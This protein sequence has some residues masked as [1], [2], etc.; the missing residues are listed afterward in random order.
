MF[1]YG[2]FAR[3][4]EFLVGCSF[5]WVLYKFQSEADAHRSSSQS[6]R[7]LVPN[8]TPYRDSI[9]TKTPTSLRRTL[10]F[11]DRALTWRW[12][13]AGALIQKPQPAST[14]H[15]VVFLYR[16][17]REALFTKP[18]WSPFHNIVP[19]KTM[20]RC[21]KLD[22]SDLFHKYI[23][24]ACLIS[25]QQRPGGTDKCAIN[26]AERKKLCHLNH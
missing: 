19:I 25:T 13:A 22:I 5:Q 3:V 9:C 23:S 10:T 7:K 2:C 26:I 1:L 21:C 14:K 11:D 18:R 8:K 20:R 16:W 12:G 4:C 15:F 24:A 17:E 6:G